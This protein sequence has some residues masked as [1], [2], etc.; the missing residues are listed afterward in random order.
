MKINFNAK[1]FISGFMV[2]GVLM[3]TTFTIFGEDVFKVAPNQFDIYV[4]GKE[5]TEISAIN[6][7]GSTYMGL[8]SIAS[9]V[10]CSVKFNGEKKA[11]EITSNK[12]SDEASNTKS[13]EVKDTNST[14]EKPNIYQKDKLNLLMIDNEEY[15]QANSI[16]SLYRDKGYG[17]SFNSSK[18]IYEFVYDYKNPKILVDNIKYKVAYGSS[19]IQSELFY[20]QI[21]PLIK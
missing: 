14:T 8:Q 18:E 5:N 4:N 7:N 9:A 1:S 20:K 2:C 13:E 3:A 6:V 15:I 12:T 10:D 11:I 17:L 19:W 16:T 21:L